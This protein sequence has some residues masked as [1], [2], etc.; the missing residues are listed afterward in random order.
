MLIAVAL[1]TIGCSLVDTEE[2][3]TATPLP[4]ANPTPGNSGTLPVSPSA[5]SQLPSLRDLVE[6]VGPAVVAIDTS[7]TGLDFSLRR[8]EQRGS[9]SG[10]II[11]SDGYIITN[12]HVISD[13]ST[14][15]VALSDGR[16]FDAVTVGRYPEGDIAVVKIEV[17]EE[18]PALDFANSDEVRVGD[19]VLAI[20]NALGLEGG[21]TVTAG[22][23]SA[24][25]RTLQTELGTTLADL[26]QTDA[27][28]NEGNSG[29]PLINLEGRVVG[30]NTTVLASAQGIGFAVS[31]NSARRFSN[32]LIEFGAV[33]RPLIGLALETIR[34]S[35]AQALGLP[36]SRGVLVTGV[37]SGPGEDAGIQELD[38]NM[39]IEGKPV[40][41]KPEFLADLWNYRP[42]DE[43][44][45]TVLREDRQ[46]E[47]TVSLD[48]RPS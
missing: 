23:V 27:A 11:R 15:R 45:V 40:G 14:L 33:R 3:E 39:E 25:G 10:V 12:D 18:L 36:V 13:A 19:W 42:G 2:D 46:I 9:G 32:D 29:G 48:E 47:I 5:I 16:V 24:R 28:F 20:G 1:L 7:T 41:S 8:V 4:V 6:Q 26:I 17:D 37:G 31:S 30:I 22:I 34:E 35:M 43:I 44:V 21:P 38:V